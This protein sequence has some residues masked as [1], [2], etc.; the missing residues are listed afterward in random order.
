MDW[1]AEIHFAN[2]SHFLHFEDLFVSASENRDRKTAF[3]MKGFTW[4]EIL[5]SGLATQH[6]QTEG[7]IPWNINPRMA[8]FRV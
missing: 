2:K 8:I 4:E 6:P 3:L 5:W 1:N 7:P